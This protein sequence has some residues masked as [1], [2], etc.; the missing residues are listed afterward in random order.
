VSTNVQFGAS[1]HQVCLQVPDRGARDP[2]FVRP[3]HAW[4]PHTITDSDRDIR[5]RRCGRAV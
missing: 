4:T 3:L 5:F 2:R 1:T